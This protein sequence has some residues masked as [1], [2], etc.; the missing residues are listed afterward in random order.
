MTTHLLTQSTTPP[1]GSVRELV[2][3]SRFSK[4]SSRLKRYIDRIFGLSSL[5]FLGACEPDSHEAAMMRELN[6][7]SIKL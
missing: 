4:P 5:E 1:R 6:F 2:P 3:F 7:M